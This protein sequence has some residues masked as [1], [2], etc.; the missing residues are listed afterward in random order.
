MNSKKIAHFKIQLRENLIFRQTSLKKSASFANF[1]QNIRIHSQSQILVCFTKIIH[2]KVPFC[3]YT[4]KFFHMQF[5]NQ[6]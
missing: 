1:W 4:V 6:V 5:K 2:E 3:R